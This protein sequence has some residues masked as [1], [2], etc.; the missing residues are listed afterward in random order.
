[1]SESQIGC[2]ERYLSQEHSI[3]TPNYIPISTT[4]PTKTCHPLRSNHISTKQTTADPTILPSE[5]P[6]IV[7]SLHPTESP[8]KTP[9]QIPT[10]YP[11]NTT[12]SPSIS[13]IKIVYIH[14]Y[15]KNSTSS[16]LKWVIIGSSLLC[17]FLC[18]VIC[19]LI[20][21]MLL[22][23]YRNNI[24]KM[25]STYSTESNIAN[26]QQTS[27]PPVLQETTSNNIPASMQ[28]NNYEGH[29]SR[30]GDTQTNYGNV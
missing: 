9:S 2:I 14:I 1:M 13:P 29:V 21:M 25:L 26:N 28:N 7:P 3:L 27:L 24:Q 30:D 20:G 16:T 17:I 23:R 5:S 10:T 15:P 8:F 4:Y 12:K 11:T 22:S 6:T 19:I 18:C